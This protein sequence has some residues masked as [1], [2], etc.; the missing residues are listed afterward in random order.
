MTMDRL[1]MHMQS[2]EAVDDFFG[3]A[4]RHQIREELFVEYLARA[5]HHAKLT[6]RR[7]YWR[8][9]AAS[10]RITTTM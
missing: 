9:S 7:C 1:T 3:D 6:L 5:A 2:T 10:R 8:S 4:A